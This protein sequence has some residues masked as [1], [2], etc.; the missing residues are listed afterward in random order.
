MKLC[1]ANKKPDAVLNQFLIDHFF[2]RFRR[3][4][5]E[6]LVLATLGKEPFVQ[7]SGQKAKRSI[8]KDLLLYVY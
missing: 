6:E 8:G 4:H 5:K 2:P 1:E 3:V 7:M